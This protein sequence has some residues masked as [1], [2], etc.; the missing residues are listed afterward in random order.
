MKRRKVEG[1]RKENGRNKE[2]TKVK[3]NDDEKRKRKENKKEILMCLGI[4]ICRC[5]FFFIQDRNET[6]EKKHLK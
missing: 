6:Q 4:N 2:E 3:N 5:P 1:K